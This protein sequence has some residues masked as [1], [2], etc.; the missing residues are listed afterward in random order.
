MG[1]LLTYLLL[2]HLAEELKRVNS[3]TIIL[4]MHPGEV[5]T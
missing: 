2:Q 1:S 3:P 4:A 5:S